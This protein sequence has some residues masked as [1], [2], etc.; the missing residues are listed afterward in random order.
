M[1]SGLD[2]RPTINVL[3]PEFYVDPWAAYRWLRDEA[4]VFW[5]PV[6]QIWAISRYEDIQMVERD[7][8]RYSS[9]SGSRPHID[10]S[11][12]ESMIN[13]DEPAHQAQRNLVSRDFT[14]RGVRL[15][16]DRIRQLV[17]E[18]LDGVL[19]LGECEAIE[20]IASRLPAMVIGELLGYP[21][22][23]WERVRY[24]SEQVVMLAGQTSPTGPPHVTH[25]DIIPIMRDWARTT[26]ALIE[27]RRVEPQDDLISRWIH[28]EGWD[29][30]RVLDETVLLLDG[31]AE[32]TRTVIGSVIR[33]LALQPEQRRLLIEQPSLLATTAVEE[34]IR[35]VSPILNMRRT[36]TEDHEIHD[37][38]IGA[39]DEILLLYPSA[40][41]DPRAFDEPDTFDVTRSGNRHVA[42]GF[43]SHFCLG[44]HL[45]R[46][47]IRVMFEEILRR[48]PDWELVDP[49]EPKIIPAT[50]ARAFDR[51]RIRFTPS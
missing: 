27:Q 32:T 42:F 29:T 14:P 47:E 1:T 12:D 23:L 39:G 43:G 19:P 26:V 11:S 48:M 7:G 35:W 9:F 18:I 4:P 24:W 49:E 41:R 21:H 36:A 44:A 5:D 34:F 20:A 15:H 31:G 22:D 13:L 46:L 3:D 8:S 38:S 50:F 51:I 33:E 16:E 25:P 40:N 30:K 10:L 28:T 37:Q 2:V 45:A 6:Q 17:T